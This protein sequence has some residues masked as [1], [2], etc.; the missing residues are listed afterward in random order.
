LRSKHPYLIDYVYDVNYRNRSVFMAKLATN[1]FYERIG[2]QSSVERSLIKQGYRWKPNWDGTTYHFSDNEFQIKLLSL[3][4]FWSKYRN[5]SIFEQITASSYYKNL[6]SKTKQ[7][8]EKAS[9]VEADFFKEKIPS[10]WNL[11][12][13]KDY[14]KQAYESLKEEGSY[15]NQLNAHR[16]DLLRRYLAI[17]NK[18]YGLDL[19]F[20][21]TFYL[22]NLLIRARLQ[23]LDKSIAD[24]LY[25]M[26]SGYSLAYLNFSSSVWRLPQKPKYLK[27]V[28]KI[29]KSRYTAFN[30]YTELRKKH[31]AEELD[32]WR[33]FAEQELLKLF[34]LD[35]A[36]KDLKK[37]LKN[38]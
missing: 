32:S 7:F 10:S 13:L 4:N 24:Y 27:K 31:S 30:T 36:K 1:N 8:I 11:E 17:K 34:Q 14:Y 15:S 9:K 26:R 37:A 35:K 2:Y 28:A 3:D 6:N 38:Q 23:A 20:K 33:R 19:I 25:T 16:E 21:T 12:Y 29:S 5:A 22:D 18:L